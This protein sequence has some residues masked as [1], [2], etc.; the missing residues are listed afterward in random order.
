[1]TAPIVVTAALGALLT[2]CGGG[3]VTTESNSYQV[4]DP[5]TALRIKSPGGLIEVVAG[6]GGSI[7]VTETVRYDGDKPS[8]SHKAADG[9][10]ALEAS[11]CGGGI[12]HKVCQVSYR[13]TVP[14]DVAAT[15]RNTGGDVSVTGLAGALDLT[16]DGG[17]VLASGLTAKSFTAKADG[18]TVNATFAD[19]PD[20]VHIESAGGSVTAHLPD[21]AYA[22]DATADGGKQNVKVRTDPGSPHKVS[23]RSDGGSVDVLPAG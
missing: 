12:G 16:A 5:V 19:A 2:A 21:A 22:V 18:G 11:E 6:A 7:E 8:V 4:S 17:K 23:I 20:R 13:V 10:L 15:V 3:K 9:S 1:V 14:K